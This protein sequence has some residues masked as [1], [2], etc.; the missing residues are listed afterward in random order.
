MQLVLIGDKV[1]KLC[2]GIMTSER[3]P[4]GNG[5][6]E[7][8]SLAISHPQVNDGKPVAEESLSKSHVSIFHL[9]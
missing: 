2:E 6:A 3:S 7:Q 4:R 9:M 1:R 8:K 5:T